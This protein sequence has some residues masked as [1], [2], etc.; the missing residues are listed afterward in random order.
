MVFA[1]TF[2]SRVATRRVYTVSAQMI[3]VMIAREGETNYQCTRLFQVYCNDNSSN[4]FASDCVGT[5]FSCKVTFIG[6]WR[7]WI[8]TVND[9]IKLIITHPKSVCLVIFFLK[10]LLLLLLLLLSIFNTTT[11]YYTNLHLQY[12]HCLQ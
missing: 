4:I 9:W 3:A 10:L 2:E 7:L 12:W 5:F 11:T 1:V 6:L 8:Y